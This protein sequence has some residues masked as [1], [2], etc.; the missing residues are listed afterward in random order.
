MTPGDTRTDLLV[1]MPI[2]NEEASLRQAVEEW[3]PAIQECVENFTFLAID[4][5]SRD[6]TPALLREIATERGGRF[7]VRTQDN[8]GHG[9]ACLTGYREACA[10]GVSFIFQIDSDGQ[11]D[12]R[13]FARLWEMR[14]NCDVIYGRRV[15]R[16]D[17]FR[18]V[19]AGNILRWTVFAATGAWCVDPNVPYRLMRAEAL[20]PY[21]QAIPADFVLAN[22]ALAALLRKSKTWRHGS[23]PIHFRA[24]HGGEPSVRLARFGKKA[25]E[26]VRQL[27]RLHSP[28]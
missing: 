27:R 3:F 14:Q 25:F 23:V 1:V 10:R 21:L 15:R 5:G 24:R 9:Q 19:L 16:D 6:G 11:C 8:R 20:P 26:L 12:P 7:E 2:F 28:A 4:D 13:Y 17:G 18:R 22:V